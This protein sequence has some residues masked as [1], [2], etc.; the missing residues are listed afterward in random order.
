MNCCEVCHNNVE[1]LFGATDTV[2][3]IFPH[4]GWICSSCFCLVDD[5]LSTHP[6][7]MEAVKLGKRIGDALRYAIRHKRQKAAANLQTLLIKMK[8]KQHPRPRGKQ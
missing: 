4:V 7:Q 5:V 2:T 6:Q 3:R 8:R 1:T